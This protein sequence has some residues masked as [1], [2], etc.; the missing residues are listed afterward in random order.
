ML[1]VSEISRCGLKY[2]IDTTDIYPISYRIV[3]FQILQYRPPL[4][5]VAII[6]S[7]PVRALNVI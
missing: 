2:R 7:N 1:F 3:S 6:I 4:L 5:K